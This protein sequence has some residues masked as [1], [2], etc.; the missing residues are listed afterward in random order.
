MIK[1]L[2][3]FLMILLILFMMD[4]KLSSVLK[5]HVNCVFRKELFTVNKGINRLDAIIYINVDHRKDRKRLI[6]KELD[7]VGAKK[8]KIIRFPAVYQKYNGHLG[9]AQSHLR[10]LKLIKNSNFENALILEDDFQFK[11]KKIVNDTIDYFFENPKFK[12]FEAVSLIGSYE[13]SEKID[14]KVHNLKY[15]TGG[16]AYIVN[17]RFNNKLIENIGGSVKKLKRNFKEFKR[18]NKN[19][20]KYEDNDAF[21]QHWG[22]LQKNSKW[23]IFKP[24]LG[25]HN[26]GISSTIMGSDKNHTLDY[27]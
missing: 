19:V 2:T 25:K 14:D 23:Y 27:K 20:K 7:N 22:D 18:K 1:K 6:L 21:N 9:A 4:N 3:I 16:I 10:C 26:D 15:H 8:S 11:D 5:N 24:Y 17:R 13:D 12:D